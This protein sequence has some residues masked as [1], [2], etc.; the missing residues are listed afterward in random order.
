MATDSSQPS[1]IV[2]ALTA[3]FAVGF[4]IQQG[5]EVVDNIVVAFWTNFDP[6]KQRNVRLKK[7]MDTV[8]SLLLAILAV[9]FLKVDVLAPFNL[10]GGT[11]SGVVSVLF[12]S[13]GTEGFNSILKWISYKKEDAK[14]DAAKQKGAVGKPALDT[15][16]S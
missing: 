11:M 7:G 12:L 3:A 14:A 13:A 4:A 10:Q 2:A 9:K 16:P 8:I 15:L 6:T 5:V 1:Q